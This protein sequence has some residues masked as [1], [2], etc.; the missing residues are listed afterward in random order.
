[1]Y[2][3]AV[4]GT[5]MVVAGKSGMISLYEDVEADDGDTTDAATE[6]RV[7]EVKGSFKAHNR[8][9]SEVHQDIYHRPSAAIIYMILGSVHHKQL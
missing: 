7:H 5:I 3:A 8:W 1:M 2:S 9:V 4:F 6:S